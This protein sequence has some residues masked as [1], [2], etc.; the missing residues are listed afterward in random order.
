M[1]QELSAMGSHGV[2]RKRLAS[3]ALDVM[4]SKAVA[5]QMARLA[6]GEERERAARALQLLERLEAYVVRLY[7]SHLAARRVGLVPQPGVV[8]VPT[9][10]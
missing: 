4:L 5:S 8:P 1:A 6:S 10:R 9:M 2:R 3:I 7:A